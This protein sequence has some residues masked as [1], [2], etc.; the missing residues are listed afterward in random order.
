MGQCVCAWLVASVFLF[1]MVAA[2][3]PGAQP[4]APAAPPA[5]QLSAPATPPA[6]AAVAPYTDVLRGPPLDQDEVN[7]HN[8]RVE[9]AASNLDLDFRKWSIAFNKSSFEWHFLST[10]IIFFV[11][12][13]IVISGLALT[14]IQFLRDDPVRIGGRAVEKEETK[15]A[16][17]PP[18]APEAI[19]ETSD[20]ST[21]KISTS[22]VEVSSRVLGLLVLAFSLGFFYLYLHFVYPME[23]L[24]TLAPT[25]AE[26]A[27]KQPRTDATAAKATPAASPAE[28]GAHEGK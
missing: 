17:G 28:V 26:E 10:K 3:S 22:G 8:A 2:E 24:R 6:A 16:G 27:A 9:I 19:P 4:S 7:Q 14:W 13:A 21:V 20:L 15:P 11:V 5:A 18:A 12:L 25:R 1:G 23:E